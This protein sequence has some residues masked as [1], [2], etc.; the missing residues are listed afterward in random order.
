[1]SP[2]HEEFTELRKLLA[3]K[4]Y[5]RPPPNYFDHLR[6]RVGTRLEAE[7]LVEY[8]SWWQWLVERFDA[9]PVLA[10]VYGAVVSGLLLAGFRLSQ[11][12][13]NEVAATPVF[14]GPWLAVTP[15]SSSPFAEDYDQS[16]PL[17]TYGSTFTA[18]SKNT[19]SVFGADSPPLL[20]N[21][22]SRMRHYPIR[23]AASTH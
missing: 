17:E 7:E 19:P 3:L 21:D 15:G 11:V 16:N 23:K 18:F 8:S 9:K 20:L 1:M 12:L 14:S 2:R 5:E 4:R 10:C 6:E 22:A 13:E